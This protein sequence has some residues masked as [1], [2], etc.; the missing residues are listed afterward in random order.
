MCGI[1]YIYN[2][3]IK[4]NMGRIKLVLDHVDRALTRGDDGLG[5][6][7]WDKFGSNLSYNFMD[8]KNNGY[9]KSYIE[10]IIPTSSI[11]GCSR[12]QPET[13]SVSSVKSMQPI[14]INNPTNTKPDISIVHN[15]AISN[16]CI[17]ELKSLGYVFESE[18]DSEAIA[19]YYKHFDGDIKKTCEAIDGGFAFIL[20][21]NVRKQLHV[22]NKYHPIYVKY[23]MKPFDD[24]SLEINSCEF[25]GATPMK[26]FTIRSFELDLLNAPH[27]TNEKDITFNPKYTY[28]V[29]IKNNKEKHLVLASGGI[30]SITTMA[31]LKA[32]GADVEALHFLYGA[33]GMEAEEQAFKRICKELN[34]PFKILDLNTIYGAFNSKSEL[35]NKDSEIRTGTEDHIKSTTAWVPGRNMVMGTIM[36]AYSESLI[37]DHGYSKVYFSAGFC[38]LEEEGFYPDN[39]FWFMESLMDLF[40]TGTIVPGKIQPQPV[41][42][43]IMKHEEWVLAK[44]LGFLDLFKY[45]ISCDCPT[46]NNEDETWYNC[47]SQCGSTILS[48]NAAKLSGI[49]DPRVFLNN[50]YVHLAK[51]DK[52]VDKFTEEDIK[53]KKVPK[54]TDLIDRLVLSDKLKMVLKAKYADNL[55]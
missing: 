44:N 38:Q 5:I 15:G 14:H 12:A 40:K 3:K 13:E 19:L 7:I 25:E 51:E 39:S 42:R 43:N 9:S 21:D 49:E 45:T 54:V 10:N 36:G 48:R 23:Y 50:P 6:N 30:D 35:L 34:V 33:K 1:F 28:P 53:N 47:D 37:L 22:C 24:I 55:L 29:D 32:A 52:F 27:L 41:L 18:C 46:Y 8:L 11:M 2:S 26:Q 17:K 16:S 20:H 4:N 31:L